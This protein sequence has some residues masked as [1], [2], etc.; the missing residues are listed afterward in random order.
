[1]EAIIIPALVGLLIL[2]VGIII[3]G[4]LTTKDNIKSRIRKMNALSSSSSISE[5]NEFLLGADHETGIAAVIKGFLQSIGVNFEKYK[6]ECE[7]KF[8]QAGIYSPNALVYYVFVKKFGIYVAAI[9]VAVLLLI[10]TTTLIKMLLMVVCCV[11]IVMGVVGADIYLANRKRRR[12]TVLQRSFPDGLDLILVCVESGLA[13]DGALARVCRELERAHPEITYEFNKTRME[14]TLLNNREKALNNLA[15]RT[16]LMPFK[17]LVG[18]LLQSEKFGTSL[19]ETIR[20][21]SEDYRYTR[22]MMAEN[23]AARIPAIMTIIMMCTMMPAFV[24]I[25]MT[26]AVLGVLSVWK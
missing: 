21:L 15:I 5:E 17:A 10:K 19:T 14:L 11:L 26:P 22:M 7:L 4:R 24:M 6:R 18:A 20:V 12:Q 8:L 9:I 16:G 13:F 25:V 3:S 1:M 2:G 23:K